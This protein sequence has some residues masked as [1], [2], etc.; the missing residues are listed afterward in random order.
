M[1]ILDRFCRDDAKIT[2]SFQSLYDMWKHVNILIKLF[3]SVKTSAS[4]GFFYCASELRVEY[5][6]KALLIFLLISNRITLCL[7]I[8]FQFISFPSN[9]STSFIIELLWNWFNVIG[10]HM[11]VNFLVL[12][13]V[14]W[15]VALHWSILH[16][17]VSNVTIKL[18]KSL[19]FNIINII[20][21]KINT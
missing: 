21:R 19:I 5:T 18:K 20:I 10:H 6:E 17:F 13:F 4:D 15:H 14:L 7:T 11:W 16:Y 2:L 12:Y 8:P 9:F 3:N 1:K